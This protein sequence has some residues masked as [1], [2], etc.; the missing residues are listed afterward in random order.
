VRDG[1]SKTLPTISSIDIC[2]RRGR[3][4][5]GADRTS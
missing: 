1:G 4:V 3:G 2:Q 5:G